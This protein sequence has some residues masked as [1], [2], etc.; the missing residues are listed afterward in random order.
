MDEDTTG[1]SPSESHVTTFSPVSTPGVLDSPELA[2]FITNESNSVVD[3]G[4]ALVS[5]EDTSFVVRPSFSID[6]DGDGNLGGGG[7][8]GVS[9]VRGGSNGV[10][11]GDVLSL[12]A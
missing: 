6:G 12:A 7:S 10:L 5:G 3:G 8:E 11:D 2:L 4:G 9:I 1:V